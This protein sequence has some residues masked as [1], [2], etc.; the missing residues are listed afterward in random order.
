MK[1]VV[2]VDYD[3]FVRENPLWDWGHSEVNP[4]FAS[5]AWIARYSGLDLY[6]E[7]DIKKYADF[8]PEN[9][10]ISL[11]DKGFSFQ[12]HP[13]LVIADSHKELYRY[14]K[15][16]GKSRVYNF[17]AHHDLWRD[18]K[19]VDCGNWL[20]RATEDG[21]VKG[22]Y[23]IAPS[24]SEEFNNGDEYWF[25]GNKGYSQYINGH[26]YNKMPIYK[27]DIDLLFICRSSAWVPPH[28]DKSFIKMIKQVQL[29]TNPLEMAG[30]IIKRD[31]PTRAEATKTFK[32]MEKMMAKFRKEQKCKK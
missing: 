1:T 6:K 3:F 12:K 11:I 7:T 26:Y 28:L 10:A 16:L 25:N 8:Q 21:Y 4:I 15:R 29:F 31:Y 18:N 2:S 30:G 9:L 14:L 22:I 27:E 20:F 23:W 24:W 13:K 32:Q 5:V 19:E 17:D